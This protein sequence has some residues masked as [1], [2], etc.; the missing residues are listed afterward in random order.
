M[1]QFFYVDLPKVLEEAKAELENE[2]S[3]EE[4]CTALQGTWGGTSPGIDGLPANL[5][6]TF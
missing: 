5:Y 4:L 6:K 1:S 3:S 2:I